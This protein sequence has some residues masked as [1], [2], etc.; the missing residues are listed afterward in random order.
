[1]QVAGPRSA[2]A[3]G[4]VPSIWGRLR[5]PGCRRRPGRRAASPPATV[6][7]PGGSRV[8]GSPL[9]HLPRPGARQLAWAVIGL[10]VL[11]I[12]LGLWRFGARLEALRE[13]RAT[14]PSWSFPSRVYSGDLALVP[15]EM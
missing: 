11:L 4:I 8:P 9:A 15:G 12:G 2:R 6:H 1:M 3:S 10:L 5:R 13:L 7:G 14:G